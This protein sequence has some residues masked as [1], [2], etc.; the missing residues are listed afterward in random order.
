MSGASARLRRA[1]NIPGS[2]EA[3]APARVRASLDDFHSDTAELILGHAFADIVG[4]DEGGAGTAEV[5]HVRGNE[6]RREP[7]RDRGNR[8][9]SVR[10]RRRS[11]LHECNCR[12]EDSI[13]G[14]SSKTLMS[15]AGNVGFPGF[16]VLPK[17]RI[18]EA[19]FIPAG[20]ADIGDGPVALKVISYPAFPIARPRLTPEHEAQPPPRCQACG[21]GADLRFPDRG[22]RY[23]AHRQ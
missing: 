6:C 7:R 23:P 5:P 20:R 18:R 10:L 11:G 14:G 12:G 2:L 4:R 15:T 21:N 13:S 22:L 19:I 17:P 8:S 16:G 3:G 9:A 1:L